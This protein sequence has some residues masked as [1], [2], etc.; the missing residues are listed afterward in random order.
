MGLLRAWIDVFLL[1]DY[2]NRVETFFVRYQW[3][4]VN[5]FVAIV[6]NFR[7]V[8]W[9]LVVSREREERMMDICLARCWFSL[10]IC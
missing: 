10:L 9:V 7:T 1:N 4:L 3:F 6:N 5:I 2:Y 8:C